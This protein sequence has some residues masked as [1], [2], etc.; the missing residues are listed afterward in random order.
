M[1]A[2]GIESTAHTFGV[3][4]VKKNG[5]ILANVKR[6]YKAKGLI[7]REL[8]DHHCRVAPETVKEALEKAGISFDDVDIVAFSQGP[9]IGNALI[10]GASVARLISLKYNIPLTAVNHCLAHIE[11]GKK[12]TKCRDPVIVYASGAN[13]QIIGYENGKYRIYG[14]TLDIGLGNLLDMFGRALGM[15]FP[16]GPV[17]SKLYYKANKYVELPYTVKG[18]DLAFSGL[19]TAAVNKIKTTDKNDLIFSL[20]HNAFAMLVEVT[21]RALSHSNKKSLLLAGGV[22]CSK[23]LQEMFRQMCKERKIRLCVPPNDVLVDNGAMIAYTGFLR[24]PIPVEKSVI[25]PK[26]RLDEI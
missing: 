6:T 26:Q 16:A 5:R 4:I 15:E 24:R 19:Y 14:E 22:C 25:K 18:M 10:V 17:L 2:L 9:G 1:I 12:L 11:I 13:T 3:G 21:E 23:P 8:F 20:L 7:P